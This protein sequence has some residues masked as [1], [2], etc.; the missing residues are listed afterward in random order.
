MYQILVTCD[1]FEYKEVKNNMKVFKLKKWLCGIVMMFALVF[2][3]SQAS[4]AV[5]ENTT[6][7]QN[8]TTSNQGEVGITRYRI[9][10]KA[11]KGLRE[12]D[13]TANVAI[14]AGSV[15]LYAAFTSDKEADPEDVSDPVTIVPVL[16]DTGA[17]LYVAFRVTAPMTVDIR[18]TLDGTR[19]PYEVS[20]FK[21]P[22]TG[23]NL[24]QWYWYFAWY[25]PSSITPNGLHTLEVKVKKHGQPWGA[26][27]KDSCKFT[28]LSYLVP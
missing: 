16:D 22:V 15:Q 19:T 20:D 1:G 12:L 25:K 21:D 10:N 4:F 5:D 26:G 24:S 17:Y 14:P 11:K 28:I 3:T 2:I 13:K 6:D 23:G 7:E 8:I 27:K 9:P 18:W